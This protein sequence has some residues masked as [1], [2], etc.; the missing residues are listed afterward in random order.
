MLMSMSWLQRSYGSTCVD[1]RSNRLGFILIGCFRI[2]TLEQEKEEFH[3]LRLSWKTKFKMEKSCHRTWGISSYVYLKE[4]IHWLCMKKGNSIMCSVFHMPVFF[5]TLLNGA[6]V[7]Y[8]VYCCLVLPYVNWRCAQLGFGLE[9][10]SHLLED[11]HQRVL[12]AVAVTWQPVLKMQPMDV[13]LSMLTG[14]LHK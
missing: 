11:H 3:E 12:H 13:I 14:L 2:T 6:P 7:T 5:W 10:T 9:A 4:S 8:R 1:W